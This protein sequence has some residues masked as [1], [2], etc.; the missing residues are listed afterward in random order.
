MR[1][2]KSDSTV[3]YAMP[4]RKEEV[5]MGGKGFRKPYQIGLLTVTAVLAHANAYA[6]FQWS[7]TAGGRCVATIQEMCTARVGVKGL[8]QSSTPDSDTTCYETYTDGNS[9]SVGFNSC[10]LPD[11]PEES[12]SASSA[13]P[14]SNPVFPG[15][16]IKIQLER[17]YQ[18][19]GPQALVF[20][21]TY[22]STVAQSSSFTASQGD[23]GLGWTHAWHRYVQMLT[24]SSVALR[25]QDGNTRTFHLANGSWLADNGSRDNLVRLLDTQNNLL[26]WKLNVLDDGST[27]TYDANGLLSGITAPNGETTR[28]TYSDASTPAAT[29]P[30]AGLLISVQNGFGRKLSF[31]YDSNKRISSVIDPTGGVTQYAYSPAGQLISVTWP[32]ATTRQYVYE[33]SR[34]PWALT[35]IVDEN[36]T[37]YSTYAYDDSGRAIASEH[38]GAVDRYQFLYGTNNQTT[39]VDP[40]GKSSVYTFLRQNGV[41]LPTAVSAPCGLCGS[42]RSSSSYDANNNLIQETDYLGNVTT[43]SYDSQNREI[44]RVEGAGTPGARTVTTVWHPKF[45]N[46]PTQIAL[47]TKLQNYSYD[48][49]GNLISYS[50][51][52][53]T[54]ANGSQGFNATATGPTRTTTWTYTADGQV[55]S[56]S[57]P[58]TDVNDGTAYVYRTADDTSSPP[59]YRKGDLYQIVDAAGHATTINQYD[60]N[61]RPLRMTDA[62]GTVTTSTYSSRGWL[63]S[64]T[65]T[66]L[67]GAGQTTSYDYDKA[68]Q[69]IK[70]NRP[71]GGTMSLSYDGAHRLIGAADSAGNSVSY[72]LDAMGNRTQEQSK[73]PSGNLARQVTRVFDSMNRPLQ[74]TVGTSPQVKPQPGTGPLVKVIPLGATASGFYADGYQATMALDGNTSTY[75]LNTNAPQWIEIDLGAPVVLRSIRLLV[76][77]QPNGPSTHVITGDVAP[78]PTNVLTTLSGQTADQQWLTFTPSDTLPPTRFI[79]IT[80]TSSSSWVS[81]R[82]L[83]F[84]K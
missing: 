43:H 1:P 52:P 80:T 36:G 44:Q 79:R 12:C 7:D 27:E 31:T 45:S 28:L 60:A 40:T 34:F 13:R 56:R 65:T 26:G 16:G 2:T 29:A 55:A 37:R 10:G 3:S 74:V 41:L 32:D 50:E 9:G 46:L 66:P 78:A 83:E 76:N 59:Q 24:Q 73:D 8:V 75:W 11:T 62:N 81:W 25:R 63:I 15:S 67:N 47:P 23:L 22:R 5:K 4:S 54:D 64:Q 58:R 57:G 30:S 77:Q 17:D 19:A 61:G 71:D 51:T 35:G 82:E 21:R 84:Y 69:L 33:D 39:V 14:V 38:A 53:T 6:G 49:G 18:G 48:T 42:T 70:V 20:E 72:T 68:G